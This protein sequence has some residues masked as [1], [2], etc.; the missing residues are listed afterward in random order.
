MC[1]FSILKGCLKYQYLVNWL[2]VFNSTPI[3]SK[4]FGSFI[5][6]LPSFLYFLGNSIPI[7][8]VFIWGLQSKCLP[9][10]INNLFEKLLVGDWNE[11]QVAFFD[12]DLSFFCLFLYFK[13]ILIFNFRASDSRLVGERVIIHMGERLEMN[14]HLS[15]R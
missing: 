10:N 1:Y 2:I 6:W 13:I 4:W 9:H 5:G 11:F 8:T 7:C 14:Y 15:V 12:V 3:L